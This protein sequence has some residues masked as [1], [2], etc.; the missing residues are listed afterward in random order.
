MRDSIPIV[1]GLSV[2]ISFAPLDQAIRGQDDRVR[3]TAKSHPTDQFLE[4]AIG[5]KPFTAYYYT[6]ANPRPFFWPIRDRNGNIVTKAILLPTDQPRSN[7]RP[8][9]GLS[10]AVDRV[11]GIDYWSERGRIIFSSISSNV[12]NQN[13]GKLKVVNAWLDNQREHL[14]KESTTV[15]IYANRL[16]TY[17]ATLTAQK[18]PVTFEDTQEG[19]FGLSLV[20]AMCESA[21]GKVVSSDGHRGASECGGRSF[22]WVDY[23]GP[24]EGKTVGVAIFDNPQNFRRSCFQVRSDGLFSINPFAGCNHTK[25]KD[26]AKPVQLAPGANLRLRYGIYVHDG[27]SKA[28]NVA[29]VYRVY[30]GESR[31]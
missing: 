17:D 18:K 14:L 8:Y 27:D 22:D 12:A 13:A 11:N 4:V 21:G 28:A 19:L 29:N 25:G 31:N 6:R 9:R 7:R 30:V 26:P 5:G 15:C 1:F 3:V 10:F 16:I 2:L 23:C 20:D 24:V